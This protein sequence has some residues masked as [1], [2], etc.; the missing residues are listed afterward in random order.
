M[1]SPELAC[2]Y[3]SLILADEDI[4]ISV[5]SIEQLLNASQITVE[6]YWIE[7]FAQYFATHDI[8]DLVKL[9]SLGGAPAT[10]ANEQRNDNEENSKEEEEDEDEELALDMDVLFDF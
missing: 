10:I 9:T 7:L 8:R 3:A 1:T 5:E 2:V 6:K 4:P